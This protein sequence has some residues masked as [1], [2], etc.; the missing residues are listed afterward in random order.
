MLQAL[1]CRVENDKK[2]EDRFHD[3]V[4]ACMN[5]YG[6]GQHYHEQN[7]DHNQNHNWQKKNN[8]GNSYL[9]SIECHKVSAIDFSCS[10][11]KTYICVCY[12]PFRE[13]TK[14]SFACSSFK[15]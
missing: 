10:V 14:V 3:I 1:K 8:H 5:N 6:N 7:S 9:N 12:Y 11:K 2:T 15:D 13:E 4:R